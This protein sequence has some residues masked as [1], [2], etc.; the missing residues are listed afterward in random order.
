[1]NQSLCAVLSG[2]L[3]EQANLLLDQAR[4]LREFEEHQDA[5]EPPQIVQHTEVPTKKVRGKKEPKEPKDPN[6]PKAPLSAY[7]LYQHA[8]YN[9]VKA[10]EENKDKSNKE[11]MMHIAEMWKQAPERDF[12]LNLAKEKKEKYVEAMEQYNN[13]ITAA[14]M[15]QETEPDHGDDDGSSSD[16][17][18]DSDESIDVPVSKKPTSKSTS[19]TS[20]AKTIISNAKATTSKTAPV[21]VVVSK[22]AISA[23]SSTA[24]ISKKA[25][26]KTAIEPPA[27]PVTTKDEQQT[28]EKKKKHKLSEV[29]DSAEKKKKKVSIYLVVVVNALKCLIVSPIQKKH[30]SKDENEH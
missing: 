22:P 15:S 16:D 30:K 21:P 5:A 17:D 4:R 1:M 2:Y 9:T 13:G 25:E 18:S 14:S 3:E 6:R 24:K 8:V 28:S 23:D 29:D 20:K 12:Y 11:V 26:T 7:F 19:S 10:M 27:T